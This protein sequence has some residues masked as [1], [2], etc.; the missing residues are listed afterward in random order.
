MA[1]EPN[2]PFIADHEQ[3]TRSPSVRFGY[4]PAGRLIP[5]RGI[6][7]SFFEVGFNDS[8]KS[9]SAACLKRTYILGW[10]GRKPPV[11]A[12]APTR[13]VRLAVQAEAHVAD[14]HRA[15][16]SIYERIRDSA[17]ALLRCLLGVSHNP[18][19]C[20]CSANQLSPTLRDGA[21]RTVRASLPQPGSGSAVA[22]RARQ[23]GRSRADHIGPALCLIPSRFR[24][25]RQV[26]HARRLACGVLQMTM[27]E[28]GLL[29]ST[30]TR[31]AVGCG[32]AK[33]YESTPIAEGDFGK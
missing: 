1:P 2:L 33:R 4:T 15:L 31:I 5:D 11:V 13:P 12:R 26:S 32:R 19:R 6:Y 21:S 23:A 9:P 8:S 25:E 10:L 20:L 22:A 7:V 17:P 30:P 24:N 16:C 29:Q 28:C 3:T 14:Q 27:T 18:S